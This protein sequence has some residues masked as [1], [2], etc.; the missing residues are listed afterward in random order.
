MMQFDGDTLRGILEGQAC[1]LD[2]H[3]ANGFPRGKKLPAQ[4]VLKYAELGL[5][6]GVGNRKR[7]RYIRPRA[8][9]TLLNEGS[10]T[11]VRLRAGD[12][13]VPPM[14]REHLTTRCLSWP[15]PQIKIGNN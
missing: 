14:I 6:V 3:D 5:Y 7:I 8:S 2:I 4:I 10:R 12:V 11:T 9:V 13:P 15:P 1:D